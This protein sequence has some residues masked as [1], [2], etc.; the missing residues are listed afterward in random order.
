M[1]PRTIL[2]Q[3][4]AD[5]ILER[6]CRTVTHSYADGHTTRQF[7]VGTNIPI[8]LPV[9]LD[10]L[11]GP[12][13]VVGPGE[14]LQGEGRT[15]VLPVHH[16]LRRIDAPLLHPEEVGAILVMTSINI[17]RTVV[18]HRSGVTCTP[19]LHKGV[20]R[21]G[22]HCHCRNNG[23]KSI[24]QFHL[25]VL[26]KIRVQSYKIKKQSIRHECNGYFV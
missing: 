17:H 22:S 9:A 14:T 1:I 20:L 26:T 3:R 19:G 13:T 16:I 21:V 7:G 2:E 12:G 11:R 10:G 23:D 8:E 5:G 15:M 24:S 6:S 25:V 4:L 18:N